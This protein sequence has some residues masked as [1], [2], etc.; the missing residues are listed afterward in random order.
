MIDSSKV[1]IKRLL[2]GCYIIALTVRL[3][4]I[5]IFPGTNYFGGVSERCLDVA[6]NVVEG[7]GFVF[8]VNIA[9]FGSPD[10]YSYEPFIDK[11]I[12]YPAFL[13][14]I[15]FVFGIHPIAAQIIQAILVSFGCIFVYRLLRLLKISEFLSLIGALL[16]AIWPNHARF[17]VTILP[18]A[19]MPLILIVTTYFITKAFV[20]SNKNDSTSNRSIVL[21]SL[22]AGL[23]LGLGV[24]SRPDVMFLPIFLVII[25][26]LIFTWKRSLK[27]IGFMSMIF[28]VIISLH[29]VRN[30]A[31]TGEIIPL[32]YSN[33]TVVWQGISQFGDTL[34]TVYSDYRI[35]HHEGYPSLLYPHGIERDRKRL[36]EGIE[37][38]KEHPVFFLSLIPRR[39]PL[40]L[41]PRGLLVQDDPLPSTNDSLDFPQH[42]QKGLIQEISTS[43][44]RAS[45]KIFSALSGVLLLLVAA[46]GW[47]KSRRRFP[48]INIAASIVA[49]FVIVLLPIN[50]E[51]R[52]FFPAV[53]LLFPLAILSLK[54][55]RNTDL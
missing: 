43:P 27:I 50:S 13:A 21:S 49:Y 36:R 14:T 6:K 7:R 9:P 19:I 39:I 11:P 54:K 1:R 16:T 26:G 12:G 47:W 52:Y 28:Y 32:G 35:A 40:L 38:I 22:L 45:I 31:L 29:T 41:V 3:I 33:G 20:L 18:E 53:I 17:E 8:F 48:E 24:L 25:C 37:I 44:V 15:Y 30:Y 42:F 55:A 4:F 46:Y 2:I 34:G 10:N 5:S 51:A 23:V